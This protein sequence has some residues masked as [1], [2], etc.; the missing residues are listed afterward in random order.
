MRISVR[1]FHFQWWRP[2]LTENLKIKKGSYIS[3]REIFQKILLMMQ[4]ISEAAMLRFSSEKVF[5]KYAANLQEKT[6]ADQLYWNR[7]SEWVFS[8][9]LLHIFRTPFS[10]NTSGWLLLRFRRYNNSGLVT[11]KQNYCISKSKIV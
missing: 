1:I 5:W 3:F 8:C 7:T 2:I 9:K 6:Y 11:V 10:K 4:L